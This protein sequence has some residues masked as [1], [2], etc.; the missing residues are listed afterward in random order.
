MKNI[1]EGIS[2]RFHAFKFLRWKLV[3][4]FP[5]SKLKLC[6]SITFMLK[7]CY[8]KPSNKRL[9][10]LLNFK[11]FT[12]GVYWIEALIKFFAE[13]KFCNSICFI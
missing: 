6:G 11:D 8:C 12:R 9:G 4:T 13:R 5:I 10:R 7:G 1:L 3:Q 2:I